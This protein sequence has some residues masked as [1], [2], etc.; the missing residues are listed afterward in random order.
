MRENL[1][2]GRLG[3][4]T[5]GQGD[6]PGGKGITC[7]RPGRWNEPADAERSKDEE[8]GQNVVDGPDCEVTTPGDQLIEKTT[9]VKEP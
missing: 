7:P 8:E 6:F 1:T 3:I 4:P 2:A 9:L 5:E